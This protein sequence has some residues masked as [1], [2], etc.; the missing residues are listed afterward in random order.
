MKIAIIG[1]GLGGMSA[2]YDLAR[3]GHTVDIY[4]AANYVGG[5]AAGIQEPGWKWSVER[6]YHHWFL[7]DRHVFGLLDELGW[8]DRVV[9]RRPKTVA[10]HAGKFYP[11]DSPLAAL[12][13]PGY[14]LMG[15]VRFGLATIYL[16]YLAGWESL[17]KQL[18]VDWMRRWYGKRVYES[19]FEPLLSGKFGDHMNEVNMAWM[20]ARLKVR[21]T[22]LATFEGGFQAFCD[23]F[24]GHLREQ[25][26]RI[27]LESPV[28]QMASLAE[29]G[30]R[31]DLRDGP[32]IFDQALV[33]TSPALLARMAPGLPAGYLQGLLDLKS[34][35][36]VVMILAIKQPLS[37]EGYYWFNM[38]KSAGYPFLALVEHTNLVPRENFGGESILYC[39][40]YL[41]TSHEYFHMGDEELLERFIPGIQ[42]LNPRFDRSWV[43]KMWV[44]RT[45]YA[46]PVPLVNHSRNIPDLRTPLPGLFF[47]SMSQ[48]YPW[49]R[50]TNFAIE[51]GRRAA[52]QMLAV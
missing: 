38:P 3:A 18:A 30:L 49:D 41:D 33:T 17:E 39:G 24:A 5:L 43:R 9:V 2:A 6:Y 15:M 44:S 14:D 51:I 7:S 40:D 26:V 46:Q 52:R 37:E 13:F 29:G 45:P 20:W 35:G 4:E 25:G 22:Q 28:Q 12:K 36:A 50:G 23:A 19:L 21:T 31:I 11:L 48:V 27:H 47:A 10:Y 1:A 42:R 8:R 34:M 16:R 32:Q